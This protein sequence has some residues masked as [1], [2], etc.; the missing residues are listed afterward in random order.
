MATHTA[1]ARLHSG[2]IAASRFGLAL[3][4]ASIGR[5]KFEDYE[6]ENIRPVVV[7]S[8]LLRRPLRRLGETTLAR[9]IGITEITIAGMISTGRWAPRVSAASSLLAAGMFTVTLSFLI[10]TPEAWHQR[11]RELKLSL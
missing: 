11:V 5:L 3:N 7:S 2:G 1:I 6:V 10:S 4:L 9:A 8:P